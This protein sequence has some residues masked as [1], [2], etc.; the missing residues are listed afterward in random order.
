MQTIEFAKKSMANNSKQKVVSN[1]NKVE[2]I[3]IIRRK[4]ERIAAL[5]SSRRIY[6]I[7]N[8]DVF[9]VESSKNNVYHYCKISFTSKSD[10]RFCSCQDFK[11]RGQIRDCCHLEMIPIGIMKNKIVDVSALSKDAKKIVIVQFKSSVTW[12]MTI[13]IDYF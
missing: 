11:Y 6:R 5:V 2:E 12:R 1:E 3:E 8:S 7:E 13:H 4:E 9:W 10:F